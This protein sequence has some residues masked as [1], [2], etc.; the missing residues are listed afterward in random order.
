MFG[1]WNL[2][3]NRITLFCGGS[4]ENFSFGGALSMTMCLI[5]PLNDI[6]SNRR[7]SLENESIGKERV[8]TVIKSHEKQTELLAAANTGTVR[9]SNPIALRVER[10]VCILGWLK[11]SRTERLGSA[12]KGLYTPGFERA[13]LQFRTSRSDTTFKLLERIPT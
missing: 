1:L 2:R 11:Y 13:L 8:L 10:D 4:S 7:Y 3:T 9:A 12:G 6:W 5:G